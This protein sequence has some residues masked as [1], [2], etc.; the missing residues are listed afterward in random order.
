MTS[1]IFKTISSVAF[2]DASATTASV[3]VASSSALTSVCLTSII[4]CDVEIP[5][6]KS[7]KNHQ[8]VHEAVHKSNRKLKHPGLPSVIVLGP[9]CLPL[10]LYNLD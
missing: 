4:S 3:L 8:H 2:F 5:N 1:Q 7:E 6:K 9:V 10:R